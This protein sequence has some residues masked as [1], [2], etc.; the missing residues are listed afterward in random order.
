MSNYPK[1]PF[2]AAR[3]RNEGAAWLLNNTPDLDYIQFVDGDCTIIEHWIDEATRYLDQHSKV[4]I[5]FGRRRERNRSASI[6]NLLCDIEWNV[7]V[8]EVTE[9]GGDIL[10]RATAFKEVNGYNGKLIAGEEPDM[11]WR[12]ASHGWQIHRIDH[13][14]TW[15]DARILSFGSWWK[16]CV[17]SGYAFAQNELRHRSNPIHPWRRNVMRI[18]VWGLFL[19]L[20]IILALWPTAGFSLLLAL[21]YG[22]PIWGG[23]QYALGRGYA[24]SHAALYGAFCI[25]GRLPEAQ[26]LVNYYRD[27]LTGKRSDIIEYRAENHAS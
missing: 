13:D 15:H 20:C 11:C 4:A 18:V 27:Y 14:M 23:Y 25:L 10:M 16:R 6:Y 8:G 19:P 3:A 26:G 2:T 1:T 12:L 22:R 9:C 7:P 21:G 5:S 17:R 24:T